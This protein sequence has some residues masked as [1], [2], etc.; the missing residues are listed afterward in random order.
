VPYAIG[1]GLLAFSPGSFRQER[2]AAHYAGAVPL[3][4]L[5][6]MLF[7]ELLLPPRGQFP[8]LVVRMLLPLLTAVF[9]F[10]AAGIFNRWRRR[11]RRPRPQPVEAG[12]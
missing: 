7:L 12:S 3:V 10:G 5:G 8:D 1:V 11:T 6:H 4:Y 9:S 2:W